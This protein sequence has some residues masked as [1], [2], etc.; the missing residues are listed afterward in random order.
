[1]ARIAVL[2]AA[3]VLALAVPADAATLVNPDSSPAVVA[4][5]WVNRSL[6]PTTAD[7]GQPGSSRGGLCPGLAVVQAA[8]TANL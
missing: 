5:R 7:R 4:Q 8:W 3:V 6:V 2:V 1:M